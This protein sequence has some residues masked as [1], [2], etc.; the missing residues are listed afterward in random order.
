MPQNRLMR[1]IKRILLGIAAG[2]AVLLVAVWIVDR[3][4]DRVPEWYQ[5]R[6]LS[7]ADRAAAAARAENLWLD[8][9][10]RIAQAYK[11]E[12]REGTTQQAIANGEP[13]QISFTADELN[14]FFDKWSSFNGW[15]RKFETYIEDPQIVLHGGRLILAGKIR[16][17]ELLEGKVVSVHFEPRIESDGSMDLHLTRVLAGQLPLPEALWS[18]QR[19]RLTEAVRRKLPQMQRN[20][21]IAPNGEANFDAIGTAMG[22][23][24]LQI[25]ENRPGDPIVFVP[26]FTTNGTQNIPVKVTAIAI[27]P[28]EPGEQERLTMTVE[29]LTPAERAEFLHRLRDPQETA[30][31]MTQE[32]YP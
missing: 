6:A 24:F 14:A 16:S 19:E 7:D 22:R 20:A 21:H 30:T 27:Q 23:L 26:L 5:P 1:W 12:R 28:I 31:V 29:P 15:D 2:L 18:S 4:L 3:R 25:M 13:I 11:L 17:I 32:E 9:Q 8:A 10:A